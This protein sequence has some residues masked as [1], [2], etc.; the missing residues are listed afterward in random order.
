MTSFVM[1][2]R[3]NGG[4]VEKETVALGPLKITW[5]HAVT[6][7]TFAHMGTH[8]QRALQSFRYRTTLPRPPHGKGQHVDSVTSWVIGLFPVALAR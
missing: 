6:A 7:W 2:G 3:A 4:L 5:L 1:V 8:P